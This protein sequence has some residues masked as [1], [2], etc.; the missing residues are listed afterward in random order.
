[1]FNEAE[2]ENTIITLLK[3]EKYEFLDSENDYWLNNRKFDDFINKKVL[4]NCLRR[5]NKIDDE[6]ILEMA[7]NH[8]LTLV[9]PSLFERNYDFHKLL[10]DGLSVETVDNINT[11]IYFID[12]NNPE[13]NV[14]QVVHQ[15]KFNEGKNTRIPDVIIY[16]NGIPLVVMEL[17]SF[18]EDA[19]NATLEHAYEQLG[20]NSETDGYRY[21]IPTLFNFNSFLVISDGVNTKVGTLTSK[22]DRYNEWKSIEGEKGYDTNCVYKLDVL[23]KGVFNKTRFLDI[24]KNN[25]FF[26]LDKNDKP[27]KIMGQYHQYFGVVKSANSVKRAI[28][29]VGDG[30]AGI[31]WHTQGSGKSYSMVML[32]HRLICEQTLK[33]P[34]IV[35]LTDR[36]DLDDQLYKTFYSARNYLKCEPQ[37][38]ISREDLVNKLNDIKQGGIILTT[39]RKFDKDNLPRNE[40]SNIIVMTDEA[41]RSHYGIYETVKYEKNKDTDEY[42]AIF[43]YGVEKYIRDALPNATFIG[44]TGTPVSNKDK[45]TTDVFGEIIDVYDMTQSIIDG[46]TVK[47]YYESRLAQVWTDDKLLNEIDNYY[48]CLE[49]TRKSDSESIEKSKKEMSKLKVILEDDDMIELF[50]KNIMEHYEERKGFL[51]GKAMIVCQ[52]RAAALKLYKKIT[53]DLF[54]KMKNQIIL[55]VTESNKDTEQQRQIFGDSDYRRTLGEEFKKDNSKYKIAIVVDMWLTG[56]DVPDLDVMYFIK[57]LKAHNLMQAIARVNRV[58]PGKEGG[59]I[60]DYI[61]LSKALD[62]ALIF[63]TDR[64]RKENVQ[65]IRKEIYNLFKEKLSILNEWF[66]RIDKSKFYSNDSAKRFAAIQFGSQFVLETKEREERFMDDFSISIK[67][68]FVVCGGIT[69]EEEKN[70]V[71]YYLAI[72]SFILKLRMSY[73]YI[74]IKDM[75]LYVSKLLADAIKGDEVKVLT[76]NKNESINV[77]ELLSAKKIAELRQ[78]N[79]PLVFMEIIKQLLE[80]AISESRKNNYFKSQEYSKRLRKILEQYSNR[81]GEFLPEATIADLVSFAGEIV[82]NEEEAN[83]VGVFGRERAFYD[84]LIR[85]R[86]AQDL[87][88]DET[89]KLIAHELKEIVEEYATTDWFHKQATRAKMRTKIKECLKKYNYPPEYTKEAVQDVIKQAEYIMEW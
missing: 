61:G 54:P 48:K 68:A 71:Y 30:K 11:T 53:E 4:F 87:L 37:K 36:N 19:S 67:Q 85:D 79:P 1:M 2:V 64:E 59:L 18:A 80:R 35:V 74:S 82:S 13:N 10:I 28:K 34:T 51:N 63:Y 32:A 23:I 57:R 60:V 52:T 55:V 21:D 5:I 8:I 27:I 12:F 70:D 76:E 84:A 83:R 81:D 88:N 58:Y 46:S 69:T 47:L 75:N 66:Y 9:N 86:S 42:E 22:I 17:K 33:V 31:I 15:V 20:S 45:Q 72:R 49:E 24:I 39:I 78:K 65:D 38:A 50:A 89:L 25:I 29:P 43:K 73:S 56:F 62:E 14:F 7:I 26:I 41:H 3:N 40:R 6:T 77:I 44:Y 16:V